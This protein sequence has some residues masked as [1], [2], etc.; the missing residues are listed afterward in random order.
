M[1]IFVRDENGDIIVID[2][3][4]GYPIEIIA[5]EDLNS[6]MEGVYWIATSWS[7]ALCLSCFVCLAACSLPW[8]SSSRMAKRLDTAQPTETQSAR[9]TISTMFGARSCAQSGTTLSAALHGLVQCKPWLSWSWHLLSSQVSCEVRVVGS[10]LDCSE[11]MQ[12][13]LSATC[14]QWWTRWDMLGNILRF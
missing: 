5:D 6:K 10:R 3:V 8:E 11:R 2:V 13:C 7:G 4:A 1:L 9:T 12:G 14:L